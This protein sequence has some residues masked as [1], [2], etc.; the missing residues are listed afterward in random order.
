MMEALGLTLFISTPL[1]FFFYHLPKI[2][3]VNPFEPKTFSFLN[4]KQTLFFPP[5]PLFHFK[6]FILVTKRGFSYDFL[7]K[8]K[9]EKNDDNNEAKRNE[10]AHQKKPCFKNA[11]LE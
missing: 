11:S 10:Q 3:L 8:K 6:P 7:I 2:P 1:F 4:P 9:R 5:K